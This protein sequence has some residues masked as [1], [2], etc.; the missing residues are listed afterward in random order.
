MEQSKKD[1]FRLYKNGLKQSS[2]LGNYTLFYAIVAN[3]PVYLAIIYVYD[4]D[5]QKFKT[6]FCMS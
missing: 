4:G 1:F 6:R 3:E 2:H 5:L